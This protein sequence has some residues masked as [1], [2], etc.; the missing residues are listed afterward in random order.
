MANDLQ[1][2]WHAMDAPDTPPALR[3]RR[4]M[5]I[6]S[7]ALAEGQKPWESQRYIVRP[8][9]QLGWCQRGDLIAFSPSQHHYISGVAVVAGPATVGCSIEEGAQ[10]RA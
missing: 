10:T 2:L 7:D 3:V 4:L 1:E 9:G 5:P 6:W 8:T